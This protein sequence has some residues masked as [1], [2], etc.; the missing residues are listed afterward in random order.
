MSIKDS[1]TLL[2]QLTHPQETARF[3]ALREYLESM[4]FA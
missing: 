4:Y 1:A 2:Y 3:N